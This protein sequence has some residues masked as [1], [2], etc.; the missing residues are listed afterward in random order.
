[1]KQSLES[2]DCV[3]EVKSSGMLVHVPSFRMDLRIEADIAEEIGR[4]YG[5]H[6]IPTKPLSRSRSEE[7]RVGKE[8]RSRWSPYH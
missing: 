2:L 7:R 4:L 3:V 6:N 1:M 5:F 8:C